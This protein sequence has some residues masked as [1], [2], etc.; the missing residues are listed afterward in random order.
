MSNFFIS[1]GVVNK[2]LLFPLVYI[3]CIISYNIYSLTFEYNEVSLL[4]AGLGY[5][6][7]ELFIFFISLRFKYKRIISK[8]KK[9][10]IKNYIK[11]YLILFFINAFFMFQ[12]LIPFYI[13]N[14]TEENEND[15]KKKYM[16]L[17][18]NNSLEIIFITL[19]TILFLKYKYYIHHII[20]L[21]LLI[22]LSVIIDL[23]LENFTYADTELVINSIAYVFVNSVMYV[24]FKYLMERKYYH[25]MD[26]LFIMGIFDCF[27]FLFSL[28]IIPIAQKT[29]G[30]YK[31]I[32]Q[33]YE[34]YNESGDGKMIL[35]FFMNLVMKG[36]MIFLIEMKIVDM[37]GPS[38]VYVSYQISRIPST[39][40]SIEGN[41][42]WIVLILSLFQILFIL[43]YLEILEFNFCSL[44]KNTKK[45]IAE[46][47][48]KQSIDE[49][50]D[51]DYE[52]DIKGY[53]I[54]ENVKIQE[55]M[56]ELN[57]M[58]EIFEEKEESDD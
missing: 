31:L 58:N 50:N 24:Y 43:F 23:V 41:N 19:I 34:F 52:I 21:I 48:R 37:L 2:K 49:S 7:G 27:L 35:I 17:F 1:L 29:K 18:I 3:I 55:K 36:L 38:F 44:N 30:S 54:S 12:R 26:I 56:K 32:F 14:S 4:I 39:I 51:I 11:D 5:S 53:D 28:V 6:V 25:Y 40:M 42:K 8:K 15:D 46:R 13:L 22:I 57:E 45:S 16:E 10:P 20:S 33:F 9:V 47:E